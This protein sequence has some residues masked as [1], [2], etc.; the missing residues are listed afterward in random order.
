M[1]HR[2]VTMVSETIGRAQ[3]DRR[4]NEYK[5]TAPFVPYDEVPAEEAPLYHRLRFPDPIPVPN[6]HV[7]DVDP[8]SDL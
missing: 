3:L 6:D 8:W 2:T 5:G 7:A 1:E 4:T